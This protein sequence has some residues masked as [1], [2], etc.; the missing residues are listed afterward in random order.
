MTKRETCLWATPAPI[1]R[2]VNMTG[3]SDNYSECRAPIPSSVENDDRLYVSDSACK[4]CR[5]WAA[6]D[7]AR[8]ESV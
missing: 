5:C 6:K 1:V 7:A 2:G 3:W 8:K 4:P